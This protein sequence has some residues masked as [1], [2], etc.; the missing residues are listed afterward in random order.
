[1]GTLAFSSKNLKYREIPKDRKHIVKYFKCGKL[2]H[3]ARHYDLRDR[4]SNK[5]AQTSSSNGGRLTMMKRSTNI[6]L[7]IPNDIV[8]QSSQ[9]N[10]MVIGSGAGKHFKTDINLLGSMTEIK[11]VE[12]KL[13]G[14]SE[15]TSRHKG[16]LSTDTRM[17]TVTLRAVYCIPSQK[18]IC[19]HVQNLMSMTS[20]H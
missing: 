17:T 11:K 16:R 1:M 6:K 20:Q 3:I 2:G 9:T 15:M 4:L 13:A 5:H 19:Y 18:L 12:A 8:N 10:Y 14:G 7:V